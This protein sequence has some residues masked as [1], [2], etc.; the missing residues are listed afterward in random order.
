M[1]LSRAIVLH[2][3]EIKENKTE[4][5]SLNKALLEA[6]MGYLTSLT[7]WVGGVLAKEEVDL[8]ILAGK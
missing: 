1:Y 8:P 3:E 5:L 6:E 4:R 2:Y 7:A